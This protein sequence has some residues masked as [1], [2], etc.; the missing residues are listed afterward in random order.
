[1]SL[2]N[3]V[4]QALSL[5]ANP[6]P[7]ANKGRAVW[8]SN[9]HG[10]PFVLGGHMNI[11]TQRV[12][13]TTAQTN[14]ALITIATSNKI[15][16]TRLSALCSNANSV[17]VQCRIGFGATTT[18]TAVGVIL[19]HPAIAAGSGVVE[20]N[21]SGILGIG[22]DGADLRITCGVPTD[23]SIDIVWSYFTIES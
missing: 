17:N 20:G 21:G 11:I 7:F 5:G 14:T 16:V 12:N 13:F 1:M 8:F 6:S 2:W 19:S 22:A 15:V 9:R 10:I 23:G 18:P 3:E 4:L